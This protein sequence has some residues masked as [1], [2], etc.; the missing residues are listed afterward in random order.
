MELGG[1]AAQVGDA[2]GEKLAITRAGDL[3]RAGA[4]GN[5]S[6]H[7]SLDPGLRGEIVNQSIAGAEVTITQRM[8][9]DSP[10]SRATRQITRPT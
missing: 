9:E 2:A 4:G 3:A 1:I 5:V 10:L 6:V 8:R 7:V